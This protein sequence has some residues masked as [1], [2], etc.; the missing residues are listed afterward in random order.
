M[1]ESFTPPALPLPTP[2]N[3]GQGRTAAQREP[4][5]EPTQAKCPPMSQTQTAREITQMPAQILPVSRRPQQPWCPNYRL[6]AG[7]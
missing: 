5:S 4:F 3:Q 6:F 7:T 2:Q 1:M